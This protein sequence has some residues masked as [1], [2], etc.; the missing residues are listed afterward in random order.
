MSSRFDGFFGA[1]RKKARRALKRANEGSAI[2]EMALL[3]PIMMFIM[4]GIFSF[5]VL[6]F[7]EIQLTET[8]CNAGR[9]LAV[10]R[11][12][13]DPCSTVTTAIQNAPGLSSNPTIT[14]TQNGT[15]IP[16][17]CPYN[18]TTNTSYLVQ[19]ATVKV[20]V[21]SKGFLAVLGFT[22]GPFSLGSQISEI[23]Q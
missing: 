2:V 16:S 5:S 14:I 9:Y 17:T 21:V 22:P 23:V 3:L 20:S 7:Q 12:A 8:V 6:L 18:A 15:Q 1:L 19:G 4:T 10:A 13:P 11:L